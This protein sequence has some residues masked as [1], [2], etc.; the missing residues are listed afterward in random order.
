V[1]AIISYLSYAPNAAGEGKST[2]P[3]DPG[4]ISTISLLEEVL[5][6]PYSSFSEVFVSKSINS[7]FKVEFFVNIFSTFSQGVFLISSKSGKGAVIPPP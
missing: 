5:Y 7:D 4:G 1:C 2:Y 3:L 6:L